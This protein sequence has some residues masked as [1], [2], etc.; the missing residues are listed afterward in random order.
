[1]SAIALSLIVLLACESKDDNPSGPGTLATDDP[2]VDS[3]PGSILADGLDSR[4]IL[5][6]VTSESGQPLRGIQVRFSTSFGS[7]TPSAVTDGAGRVS[8]ILTSEYSRED[9]QAQVCA[10]I[11]DRAD[12]SAISAGKNEGSPASQFDFDRARLSSILSA[13]P[14]GSNPNAVEL[15][16]LSFALQDRSAC[17]TET[18]L[19]LT[20]SIDANPVI[21]PADGVSHTMLRIAVRETE[22]GVPV[23]GTSL[24]FGTTLG[25]IESDGETNDEGVV[26]VRL[27][28]VSTPDTAD[29]FVYLGNALAAQTTIRFTPITMELSASAT[30]L[31]ANGQSECTITAALLSED[32]TP[33]QGVSLAFE[34]D[35]GIVTSPAITDDMG[36]AHANLTS[37]EEAGTANVIVQS[38]GGLIDTIDV[39]FVSD[40]LPAELVLSADPVEIVADGISQANLHAMVID[41]T[42]NQVPDGTIVDFTVLSGNGVVTGQSETKDGIAEGML[43]SGTDLSTVII[44]AFSGG[45]ADTISVHCIHGPPA[46]LHLTAEP[47]TLSGNGME[48]SRILVVVEDINGNPVGGG[49]EVSF[50][51]SRGEIEVYALTD[52]SGVAE[53]YYTA[54]TGAGEVLLTATVDGESGTAVGQ[55]TLE[56]TSGTPS[57][58]TLESVDQTAINVQGAGAPETATMVFRIFDTNG[59]MISLSE[60]VE[61]VFELVATTDGGG[62]YLSQISDT[63]DESGRVRTTLNSGTRP[64]VTEIVARIASPFVESQVIPITICGALP[65]VDHLEIVADTVN[66]AGLCYAGWQDT[67]FAYVYDQFHNPVV[68]GTG[69]YFTSDYCGIIGSAV[70]DSLGAARAM[71][72]STEPY[73]PDGLVTITVQTADSLGTR[74]EHQTQIRLSGCTAPIAYDPGSFTIA[75]GGSQYFTYGVSDA[76]GN[77]LMA[78]TR[79]EVEC[80]SGTLAGDIDV[81][82]SDAMSGNTIFSFYLADNTLADALPPLPTFVTIVVTSP[83]GNRS[84]TIAG[85]ID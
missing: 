69:L 11:P 80:T 28:S 10:S 31:H 83:N 24:N 35:L 38:D 65:H 18:M 68:E 40:F 46:L 47:A 55:I 34:T 58:I 39:T 60:Q 27:T 5:A 74:I 81:T 17:I 76:N 53:V 78:G 21:V 30:I 23:E 14:N 79:I 32:R 9:V 26:Q 49:W 63:T 2:I 42:E 52:P 16:M 57:S 8:A 3:G 29:V 51:A 36:R 72:T 61:V 70:S 45:V 56:L 1:M 85:T 62:E 20:V 15:A 43:T 75:D 67:I 12:S 66:I 22:R 48:T 25:T 77:P 6:Y 59:I 54:G 73:P 33:L 64:G 4:E 44:A 19:G 37:A 50:E 13:E 71:F 41:S 84:T 82:L 7:I